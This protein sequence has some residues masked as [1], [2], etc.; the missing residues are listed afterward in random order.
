L[1]ILVTSR[2]VLHVYGEHDFPVP[3]LKL[4]DRRS[5]LSVRHLTQYE[6]VRLF[7]DR[8]H[9]VRPE[10]AITDDNAP[11][12][13]EICHRL[14]GL[15]LAIELAAARVQLLPPQAMLARLERRLSLLTGGAR[16]LPSRQRSLRATIQWS[17]DLLE[18]EEQV[19]FRRLGAFLGGAPL[20]GVEAV[21][22]AQAGDDVN[23]SERRGASVLEGLA[24]L[25]D[26]SLLRQEERADAEPRFW[27]L[28]TIREYA[29][30]QLGA[31]GEESNVRRAHARYFLSLAEKAEP[32]LRGPLQATWLANLEAE[33]DNLRTALGWCGAE[34]DRAEDGL[35]LAGALTWF[36]R[37]RGH[38]SE[39]CGWLEAVLGRTAGV[40]TPYRRK[41]L[42]GGAFL[43]CSQGA[44][45]RASSML[46]EGLALA[47]SVDDKAAVGW[48][49]H[50]LARVARDKGDP[51]RGVELLRESLTSFED[52]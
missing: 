43:V 12:V 10:F 13:A 26:K 20:E 29:I 30:E 51:D 28:E 34:P 48:A 47:Q 31:C 17:H 50:V 23:R 22:E 49:L 33:H 35:R 42:I 16:D 1:T 11:A 7:I 46:E 9:A 36:W 37:M 5:G 24:S 14:D 4:P 6:A 52:S 32:K 45:A 3:P 27:M 38:L 8:A 25:V 2:A 40:T 44:Y 41:A 15:P 18:P 21:W 19:L 39:G